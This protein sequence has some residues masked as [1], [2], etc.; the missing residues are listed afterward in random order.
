M[1]LLILREIILTV[2]I[3]CADYLLSLIEV[4]AKV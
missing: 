4:G 2:H 3:L 1:R